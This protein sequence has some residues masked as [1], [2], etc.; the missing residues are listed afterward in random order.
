MNLEPVCREPH[1]PA[2][3]RGRG[4]RRR[5]SGARRTAGRAAGVG[6]PPHPAGRAGGGGRGD[7]HRARPGVGRAS[8]AR[9]RPRVR[10][11]AAAGRPVAPTRGRRRRRTAAGRPRGRRRGDVADQ[12]AHA[13]PPQ[14]TDRGSG[15]KRG[16]VGQRLAGAGGRRRAGTGRPLPETRTAA[17]DGRAALHRLGSLANTHRRNRSMPVFDTPEPISVTVELGVG[18]LRIVTG[19]RADTVVEVRPSDPAKKGDVTAAEQTRVEY[20][21]GRLLIKAPK[22][23][24]RYTPREAATRST[25]RSSCRPAHSCEARPGWRRC[26]ARVASASATTRPASAISSS[27]RR[28]R[29]SSGPA[30]ATSPWNGPPATPRSPPGPARCGSTASTARRWSR[31]PTATSGS[32]RSPET[33]G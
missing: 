6:D 14:G 22:S 25:C 28:A 31:T 24:R 30:L 17:R 1:P 7:H 9:T 29:C 3:R 10:G 12:P 11:D 33:C 23:W 18:D 32:A 8:P 2:R 15:R 4:R 20:T 19:D 5:G 21:G 27:T 26:A 13:R 16:A